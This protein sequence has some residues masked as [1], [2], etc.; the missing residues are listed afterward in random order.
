LSRWLG[1]AI[2]TPVKDIYGNTNHISLQEKPASLLVL[3]ARLFHSVV[4]L[5]S[6]LLQLAKRSINS[7]VAE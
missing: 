3:V 2:W 7:I 6:Y 1:C 5:L 4:K